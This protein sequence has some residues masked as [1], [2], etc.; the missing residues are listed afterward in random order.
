LKFLSTVFALLTV[1]VLSDLHW[2]VMQTVAWAK[3]VN[4]S[5]EA[6]SFTEKV[7]KTVSGEAPCERCLHLQSERNSEEE[8][9]LD[10]VTKSQ[11]FA[12]VA[13]ARFRLSHGGSALFSLAV[14][15]LQPDDP[16]SDAIDHPP[17]V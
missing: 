3:M 8:Q 5:T 15:E 17:R 1:L 12:P 9:T 4:D 14:R 13:I 2:G 11:V 16:G 10:F 6:T 7:V